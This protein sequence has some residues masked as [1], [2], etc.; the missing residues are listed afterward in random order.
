MMRLLLCL[1]LFFGGHFFEVD[2]VLRPE[3]LEVKLWWAGCSLG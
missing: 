2:P 3:L 1:Y